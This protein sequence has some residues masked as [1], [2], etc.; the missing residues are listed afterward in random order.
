MSAIVR[1]GER[2]GL[3]HLIAI[4]TGDATE[5]VRK[6]NHDRL[7]TFGVGKDRKPAEWRSIFRQI[8]AIGLDRAGHDGAWPLVGDR[9]GLEGPEGRR[10][11]RAAQ[12]P[13][14]GLGERLAP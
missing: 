11:D 13:G 4:V 9:R 3:E 7:P 12:R 2:F 8:S 6:F 5:N 14:I 1:T 10:A